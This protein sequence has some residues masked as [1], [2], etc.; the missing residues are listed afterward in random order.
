MLTTHFTINGL[1]PEYR[2][3][4]TYAKWDVKFS[5]IYSHNSTS[6]PEKKSLQN[7]TH[8]VIK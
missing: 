1:S 8:N 4:V 3:G 6:C 7:S 2:L 5:L